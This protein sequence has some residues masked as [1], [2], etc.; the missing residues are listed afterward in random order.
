MAT[1]GEAVALVS[2]PDRYAKNPVGYSYQFLPSKV[3]IP[4]RYAKNETDLSKCLDLIMFQ[5]LIGTLKTVLSGI[6]TQEIFRFQFLIGTLK[7]NSCDT[8]HNTMVGFQFLI[9]T[10]KTKLIFPNA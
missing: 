4:D 2:I 6:E 3:S 8:L 5:F 1:V 9:G 10:L 7:T